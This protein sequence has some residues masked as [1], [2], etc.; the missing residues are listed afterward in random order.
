VTLTEDTLF[1]H[2]DKGEFFAIVEH[3]FKLREVDRLCHGAF[4]G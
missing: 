1:A 2:I 4:P 3:V